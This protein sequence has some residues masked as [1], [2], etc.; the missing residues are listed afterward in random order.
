MASFDFIVDTKPMAASVNKV[1]HHVTA[2]TAAV[3]AMQ[4]A[5]IKSEKDAADYISANVDKGFFH[6]IRSQV[7][8]KLAEQVTS[9]SVSMLKMVEYA[10]SLANMQHRMEKDVSRIKRQYY[11]IFHGLDKAMENRIQQLDEEA[12]ELARDRDRLISVKKM[13]SITGIIC[14]DNEVFSTTQMQMAA[15]IKRR[16]NDTLTKI[17]GNVLLDQ[18][19]DKSIETTLDKENIRSQ[20]TVYIPVL[21]VSEQSQVLENEKSSHVVFPEYIDENIADEAGQTLLKIIEDNR[22][23][24]GCDAANVRREFMALVDRDDTD[25]RVVNEMMRLFSQGGIK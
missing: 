1:S 21:Y 19:F 15:R 5:V 17:E 20:Q 22:L 13:A 14:A 12:L 4:A 10:K 25:A 18:S 7:S 6:L 2:T 8:S 11:K 9:M 16:T 24:L 3:A 23:N